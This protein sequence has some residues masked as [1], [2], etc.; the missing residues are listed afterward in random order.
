MMELC[1]SYSIYIPGGN[2]TALV[3]GLGYTPAERKIINDKIMADNPDVEQVGFVDKNLGVFELKMAGGEFCGNATRSAAHFY[4]D[5]KPGELNIKIN[6][7][8]VKAGV[9]ENGDAW[10][11]IP[12]IDDRSKMVEK[13]SENIYKVLMDGMVTLVILEEEA[14]HYLQDKSNIKAEAMKLIEKYNLKDSEAVGV[15]FLEQV[16]GTIKIN[17]IVWVNAIDTL[18][19]ETAC[20][21]GTT[22]TA[23]V[24]S[25]LIG[26]DGSYEI[27]Q[28]SGYSITAIVK[29]ENNTVQ[30]VRIC[31]VVDTDNVC[32]EFVVSM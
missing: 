9:L 4:M 24:K 30:S 32:K 3:N 25:F 22:A 12:L 13:I 17:P 16:N 5:G 21:S 8:V 10:C 14:K 31:G 2:N 7:K 20:G 19:Y 29:F 11:E 6:N 28:P 27:L 18:F 15:M 23:V 1:G 26:K